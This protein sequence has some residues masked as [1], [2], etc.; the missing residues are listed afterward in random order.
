MDSHSSEF[1]GL[2]SSERT[3]IFLV[4]VNWISFESYEAE[5][6][7]SDYSLRRILQFLQKLSFYLLSKLN[8]FVLLVTLK[9]SLV[10]ISSRRYSV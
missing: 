4:H 7:K 5:Y 6:D 10:I 9:I 8:R 3:K 2:H 1:K